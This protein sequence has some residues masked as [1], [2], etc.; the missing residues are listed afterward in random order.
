MFEEAN[1]RTEMKLDELFEMQQIMNGDSQGETA[2]VPIIPGETPG[3]GYDPNMNPGANMFI[4][5][6]KSIYQAGGEINISQSKQ[7]PTDTYVEVPALGP[8]APLERVGDPY[9]IEG[10]E[11]RISP[12][13]ELIP[14]HYD[15]IGM[16]KSIYDKGLQSYPAGVAPGQPAPTANKPK[17]M[18]FKYG[19]RLKNRTQPSHATFDPDWRRPS[20]ETPAVNPHTTITTFTQSRKESPQGKTLSHEIG[21]KNKP[22]STKVRK[23]T[24]KSSK[25]KV[26]KETQLIE[27]LNTMEVPKLQSI[28]QQYA[29]GGEY[30]YGG[31]DYY[32][33]S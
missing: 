25:K 5:G 20:K 9:I 32:C 29:V 13:G 22:I 7:M 15:E 2:D 4:N 8:D 27:I 17:P 6:G 16:Q 14:I 1:A 26:S 18:S 19:G 12:K 23:P 3:M 10:K 21:T 28:L 31:T 24:K 33:F 30:Q 11:Y